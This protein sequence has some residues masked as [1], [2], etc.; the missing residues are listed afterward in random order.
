[1]III[2][3][4]DQK[5]WWNAT[6]N[7]PANVTSYSGDVSGT[8]THKT[9]APAAHT[10]PTCPQNLL[11]RTFLR[12]Y[13]VKINSGVWHINNDILSKTDRQNYEQKR[14]EQYHKI[15]D[16]YGLTITPDP[17]QRSLIPKKSHLSYINCYLKIKSDTHKRNEIWPICH[18]HCDAKDCRWDT[19]KQQNNT[20]CRGIVIVYA[21]LLI[22]EIY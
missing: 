8:P 7:P 12:L 14:T 4:H 10:T 11:N 15:K 16:T 19:Q 18:N 22:Y 5:V 17:H 20:D 13:G 1:M 3:T 6:V 9:T 2:S 21:D